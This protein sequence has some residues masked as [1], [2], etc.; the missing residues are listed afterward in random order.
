MCST[1]KYSFVDHFTAL[2]QQMQTLWKLWH[3]EDLR[4]Y[5]CTFRRKG[6][7]F[8]WIYLYC[9]VVSFN[10]KAFKPIVR[11]KHKKPPNTSLNSPVPAQKYKWTGWFN[12]AR[13][14]ATGLLV[15]S[16]AIIKLQKPYEGEQLHQQ[17]ASFT[18]TKVNNMLLQ[19]HPPIINL[20]T[21][22]Y[23]WTS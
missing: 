22:V 16:E 21:V 8:F 11:N 15:P 23:A 3:S 10:T 20:G 13:E 2:F 9:K 12:E 5:E 17:L 18:I 19:M 7:L 14:V 4:I 6:V 1:T